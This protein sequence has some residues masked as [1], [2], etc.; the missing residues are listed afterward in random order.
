MVTGIHKKVKITWM[1][2]MYLGMVLYDFVNIVPQ[3]SM[4]VFGVSIVSA[5]R[6]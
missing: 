5:C 2:M 3:V 6:W 1:Y 4:L